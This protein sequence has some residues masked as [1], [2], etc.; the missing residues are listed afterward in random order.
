MRDS[1]GDPAG[2]TAV[3]A[4]LRAE[5][6]RG[7]RLRG[8]QVPPTL[9][10]WRVVRGPRASLVT[11][12]LGRTCW[13]RVWTGASGACFLCSPCLLARPSQPRGL[14]GAA[15]GSAA[16]RRVPCCPQQRLTGTALGLRLDGGPSERALPL[17]TRTFLWLLLPL[18]FIAGAYLWGNH[19]A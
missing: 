4:V 8:L 3:C 13:G 16:G 7:L 1:R 15:E 12:R 19:W 9:V 17:P 6:Q 5:E 2:Y 14:C 11:G 18:V 10:C